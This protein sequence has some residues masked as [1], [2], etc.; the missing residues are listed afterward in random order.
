[1]AYSTPAA[2]LL[3]ALL[4]NATSN[5]DSL[6]HV[7]EHPGL[8]QQVNSYNFGT[9]EPLKWLQQA[10]I[11]TLRFSS[12]GHSPPGAKLSERGYSSEQD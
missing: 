12:H 7:G 3:S 8:T 5:I 6:N 9:S 2:S 1:M 11:L 4:Q 10:I